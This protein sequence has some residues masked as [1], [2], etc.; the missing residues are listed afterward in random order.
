[1]SAGRPSGRHGR[2][3]SAFVV[4]VA[5]TIAALVC[6]G[7]APA[8][9]ADS[10]D[11]TRREAAQLADELERT[12]DRLSAL[13]EDFNEATARART[14]TAK[15]SRL[16]SDLAVR[17]DELAAARSRAR[18]RALDAYARPGQ[19][20]EVLAGPVDAGRQD[21]YRDLAGSVQADSADE[22]RA[23]LDD[24]SVERRRLGTA[25]SEAAEIVARLERT[26]AALE[27]EQA[28]EAALLARSRGRL[29]ALVE[30]EERR[31]DAA[32]AQ[33]LRREAE[34]RQAEARAELAR[35]DAARTTSRATI[36]V[37]GRPRTAV[38]AEVAAPTAP[39]GAVPDAQLRVEA[40]V[41]AVRAPN[42]AASRA[43][44]V[45]LAQ[46]GKPYRWGHDGPSSYDCSGLMLFAW[47][48]AGRAL[49]HS[50][51]MQFSTTQRVSLS[52]L[53]P[54]D[55]LFFGRP[56]HHV[57]MY[58]GDENMVEASRSGTPVRTRSIHRRDFVGA[59]RVR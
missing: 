15:V 5:T 16:R 23:V 37:V 18:A 48:S 47:S 30:E 2:P 57:G 27:R 42:P 19:G 4:V 26:R 53:Q 50:S 58:I 33:R 51:R 59:G 43:V 25:T 44:Q 13:A 14:L 10:V 28:A 6:T 34:R 41:T 7:R 12:G 46:L 31:R 3:A 35:R 52:Q 32:E 17:E 20:L 24:L 29:A 55:L 21:V 45:A 39:V 49:P 8:P 9:A 11:A 1:M 56:I 54:G 40:G 36:P 38:V 22:L